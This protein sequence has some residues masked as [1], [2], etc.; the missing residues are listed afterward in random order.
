MLRKGEQVLLSES[1]DERV[2]IRIG[3]GSLRWDARLL[4]G[5]SHCRGDTGHNKA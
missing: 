1:L 2:F 4:N 5:L 3:A